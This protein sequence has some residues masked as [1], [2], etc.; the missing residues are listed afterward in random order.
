MGLNTKRILITGAAGFIG[1]HLVEELMR[2]GCNVRAFVHYNALNSWGWLDHL[3]E[4]FRKNL[5]IFLGDIRYYICERALK[6]A[7]RHRRNAF[8]FKTPR[9]ACGGCLH[10]PHPHMPVRRREP[11]QLSDGAAVQ[12]AQR[13]PNPGKVVSMELSGIAGPRLTSGPPPVICPRG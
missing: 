11:F 2:Q 7:V 8:F 1:S 4:C 12:R 6:L 5:N 9:R 3:D 13:S 10:E